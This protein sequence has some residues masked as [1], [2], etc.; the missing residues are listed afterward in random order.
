MEY[1]AEML[2][3]LLGGKIE[4]DSQAAVT[5]FAKIEEGHSGALSFLANLKYEHYLYT[6]ESSIVMI[7][8]DLVLQHPVSATLI[9]VSDPYAAFAKLLS[10]Y[11]STIQRRKGISE[12]A[13]VSPEAVLG[14]DCYVGD[15]AV[16]EQGARLGDRVV[17]MAGAFVGKNVVI[18]SDTTINPNVTIYY[19]C[20]VGSRVI[21]H[22]G[23]VIGADGF[24]F[25]PREDGTY[26][27]IP[28]IGNVVVEDD[29]EI[30]ANSCLDRATM[31]STVVKKGV[32]LDNMV[33]VAHNVIIGENTVAAAQSGFAGSCKVGANCMFGGQSGVVGH[34]TVGDRVLCGAK[35]GITNNVADGKA[36]SGYPALPRMVKNRLEIYYRHLPD[37]NSRVAELEKRLAELEGR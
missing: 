3:A 33:Q 23:A 29:V 22:A 30:G 28:Q 35:C 2:A 37:L 10:I 16:I 25:A 5:T 9:R 32:K 15:F 13:S 20:H 19:N 17:V 21:I 24:G 1:T 34:L 27:K 18:G 8:D 6:T 31:G 4:G 14:K 7:S 36:M 11:Q 26:D 12:R